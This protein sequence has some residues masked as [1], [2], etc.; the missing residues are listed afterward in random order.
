MVV[1]LYFNNPWQ[2]KFFPSFQKQFW[3]L[4]IQQNVDLELGVVFKW[5]PSILR[6]WILLFYSENYLNSTQKSFTNLT[7]TKSEEKSDVTSKQPPK[8]E[9]YYEKRS[10]TLQPQ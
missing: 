3:V 4:F 5:R 6:I 7:L 10:Y 1:N 9:S 2:G 8:T